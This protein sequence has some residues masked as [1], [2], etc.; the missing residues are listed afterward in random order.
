LELQ[1]AEATMGVLGIEPEPSRKA[2]SVPHHWAL[3][4]VPSL[5]V[6]ISKYSLAWSKTTQPCCQVM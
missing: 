3:S 2:L 6:L 1:A 5:T 4:S